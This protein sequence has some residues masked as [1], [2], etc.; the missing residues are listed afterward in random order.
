MLE[1]V[2]QALEKWLEDDPEG[3]V[4]LETMSSGRVTGHIVS[5]HFR[6]LDQV[7][8]QTKIRQV[9]R[10]GLGPDAQNLSVILTYTPHE[11]RVMQAA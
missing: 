1:R 8:R 7:D 4:E 3:Y 5:R 6:N 10:D 11:M 2:Q 9:L